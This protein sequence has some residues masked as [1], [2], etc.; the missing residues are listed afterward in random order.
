MLHLL[1][2][3]SKLVPQQRKRRKISLHCTLKEF[4]RDQQPD[5]IMGPPAQQRQEEY[6]DITD[7]LIRKPQPEPEDYEFGANGYLYFIV[8]S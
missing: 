4:A 6:K 2:K 1:K 8:K 3:V 7:Q 5:R